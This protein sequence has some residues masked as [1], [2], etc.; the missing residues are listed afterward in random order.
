MLVQLYSNWSEIRH[1]ANL[2]KTITSPY[3][4]NELLDASLSRY[5]TT[6]RYLDSTTKSLY[7]R[8][9]VNLYLYKKFSAVERRQILGR[10]YVL[11]L[12]Y[13]SL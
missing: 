5:N 8:T 2:L 1:V 11:N 13:Y 9:I 10:I 3:G 6:S 4:A 12:E 7:S